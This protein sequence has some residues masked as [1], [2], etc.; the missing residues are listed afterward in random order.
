MAKRYARIPIQIDGRT[1]DEA[2]ASNLRRGRD[3]VNRL[4]R[5]RVKLAVTPR[6]RVTRRQNTR[7]YV[8][9]RVTTHVSAW[10]GRGAGPP[11][12]GVSPTPLSRFG[13]G[14][15]PLA[16]GVSPISAPSGSRMASC[17]KSRCVYVS[18]PCRVVLSH[19]PGESD[20]FAALRWFARCT[21]R[22][23]FALPAP[24]RGPVPRARSAFRPLPCR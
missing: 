3:L 23:R 24:N 12:L 9:T 22:R 6:P 16:P 21:R 19:Y 4:L 20:D 11:A 15:G 17:R 2:R 14:P 13:R 1:S 7:Q 18:F 8:R 5:S 10:F